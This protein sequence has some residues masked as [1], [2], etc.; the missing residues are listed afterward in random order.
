[1]VKKD[2][3]SIVTSF[4]D[5]FNLNVVYTPCISAVAG[6]GLW[7]VV[8]HSAGKLLFPLFFPIWLKEE[9]WTF[10]ICLANIAYDFNVLLHALF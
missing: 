8:I 6:A 2:A 9:N 1:M 4:D 10:K 5:C 3:Y 7:G